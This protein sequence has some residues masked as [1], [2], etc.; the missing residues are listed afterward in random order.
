MVAGTVTTEYVSQVETKRLWNA[1]VKDGHN[2]YPKALHEFNISSVT[3]LQGDGG[4]GTV[5]QLNFTPASKDFSYVKERLDVIDE[6]KMVHKYAAIEGGSLG[7]KLSALNFELKFVHRE[8]GGCALTWICNYETLPGAP[9]G[10]TRVE[11]IK[12]MDDAMFKKIEEYLIS[13]P[14]LYC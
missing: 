13:N 3:V 5:R 14:D 1:M 2:L 6:D 8:E 10:E 12:K 11:E 9:D 7:K 4:V